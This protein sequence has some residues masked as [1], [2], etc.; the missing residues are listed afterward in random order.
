M[1]PHKLRGF[2]LG[3]L[4]QLLL[5]LEI[6]VSQRPA[7]GADFLLLHPTASIL[8]ITKA[9]FFLIFHLWFTLQFECG[10]LDG[11]AYESPSTLRALNRWKVRRSSGFIDRRG[12]CA[13]AGIGRSVKD[14]SA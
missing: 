8:G 3:C 11:I 7:D 6:H 10:Y 9:K 4:E 2:G 1:L 12:V 14:G 5:L 13:V